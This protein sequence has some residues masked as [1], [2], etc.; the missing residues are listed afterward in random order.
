MSLTEPRTTSD[1]LNFRLNRLLASSGAM[2]VRLCE[3]RYGITR[4]EWRLLALLTE[5]GAMSPSELAQR[6]NLERNRVSRLIPELVAKELITRVAVRGDGRRA[7]VAITAAGRTLY[8][9]LLPQSVAFSREVLAVLTDAERDAFDAALHKLTES[10]ERIAA[11]KPVPEK[12]DRRH[13]G[14]RRLRER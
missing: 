7:E 4:R 5:H 10:A 2:I 1:L 11:R 6:A 12:A 3:G 8:A 9:E 13:G 14:A